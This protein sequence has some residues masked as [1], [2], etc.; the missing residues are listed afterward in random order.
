MTRLLIL[1]ALAALL[2]AG[3][4]NPAPESTSAPEPAA[5]A[6]RRPNVLLYVI[7]TLRADRVGTY[8]YAAPTTPTI[9]RV[10]ARGIVFENAYAP[11]PWTL[12]SVVSLMLSQPICR[13]GVEVDGLEIDEEATPLAEFLS[14]AGYAT[15]S[16]VSNSYAGRLSGLERGFDIYEGPA[17]DSAEL[18]GQFLDETG[19]EPFF[20]YIHDVHPHDPYQVS[21]AAAAAFGNVTAEDLKRIRNRSLKYRRLTRTDF[22]A[23]AKPGATDNTREQ[24]I[25]LA[26]LEQVREPYAVAYDARIREADEQVARALLELEEHGHLEDTVVIIASDH[27]EELGDHG[28]WL[29]DQSVYEELV[30]TPLVVRLPK[31]EHGGRRIVGTVSLLDVAPTIAALA[32]VAIPPGAFEGTNLVPLLQ[33]RA[34]GLEENEPRVTTMRT[35]HKKY[36]RPWKRLRGDRNLVVREGAWKAIWN[37]EPDT[38][39]LF[40]LSVDPGEATNLSREHPA[41]AK[42]LGDFARRYLA[43]CAERRAT[44]RRADASV[45][46][47][48]EDRLRALGYVD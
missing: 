17:D 40:D 45:S 47:E 26:R 20:V 32:H 28:G 41:I 30:R 42:R 3:C 21:P 29:H 9:D 5:S 44:P 7:D 25:A 15:A 48:A 2:G 27:G 37:V 46:K 1:V 18:L 33:G 11:G 23:G 14:D 8:G 4:S 34:S 16:F 39:E 43:R 24:R 13:H 6:S 31:D 36:Y 10:A 35:N 12:P 38:V 19:D 22:S